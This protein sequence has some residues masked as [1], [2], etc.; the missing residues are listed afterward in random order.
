MLIFLP[1]K[2][3]TKNYSLDKRD[4]ILTIKTVITII[5]LQLF[6]KMNLLF[7]AEAL[8]FECFIS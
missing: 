5:N 2:S 7:P 6:S 4:K 3:E 8:S 1:C